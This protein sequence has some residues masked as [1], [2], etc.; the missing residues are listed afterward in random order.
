MPTI[1]VLNEEHMK[2]SRLIQFINRM[3]HKWTKFLSIVEFIKSDYFLV[4]K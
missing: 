2:K 4:E 3:F 1:E